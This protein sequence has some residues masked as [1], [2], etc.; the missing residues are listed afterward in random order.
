MKLNINE[1]WT[2]NINISNSGQ[3]DRVAKLYADVFAGPPWNEATKCASTD[4]Y[5]GLDQPVGSP[6]P[7]CQTPLLEAYPRQDTISYILKELGQINPV[8][9]LAFVKEELAGFSWGYETTV[10]ALVT[11]KWKTSEMQQAVKNILGQYGVKDPVFYGSETGVDPKY[12]G[13]GIGKTL[14]RR[15]LHQV[16][17]TKV[18]SMVV[19]TNLN[20][21]MYGICQSIGF[22]Q[23]LGPTA[24]RDEKT[25]KYSNEFQYVNKIDSENIDRVLFLYDFKAVRD[26]EEKLD[27]MIGGLNG[28]TH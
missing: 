2:D 20:S 27:R 17:K 8:G 15:R 12:Q 25:G 28:H 13:L 3:I 22:Q 7:D 19:R 26:R 16:A 4:S 1:M 14:V 18:D 10:E 9:L 6:C 5:Y 21:P 23:I 11:S 24:T